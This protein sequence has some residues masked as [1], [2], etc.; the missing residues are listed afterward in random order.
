MLENM[1]ENMNLSNS[2]HQVRF[3]QLKTRFGAK[4]GGGCEGAA[5]LSCKCISTTPIGAPIY[6]WPRAAVPPA[7]PVWFSKKCR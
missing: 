1:L 2:F 5:I 6:I 3:L 7:P 4:G